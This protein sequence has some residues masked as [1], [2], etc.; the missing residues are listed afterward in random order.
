MQVQSPPRFRDRLLG[1]VLLILGLV[2]A[3]Q[4]LGWLW[5]LFSSPAAWIAVAEFWQE[6]IA[7]NAATWVP[8]A[9][10]ASAT[11]V[12]AFATWALLRIARAQVSSDAPFLSLGIID[13][14]AQPAFPQLAP[15]FAAAPQMYAQPFPTEDLA[16]PQLAPYIV[17]QAP[18]YVQLVVSN[19]QQK[20]HGA[21]ADI[22]IDM[23]LWFGA[24]DTALAHPYM[25]RRTAR[26]SALR[27]SSSTTGPIFNIGSLTGYTVMINDISYKDVQGRTRRSAVGTSFFRRY[28]SGAQVLLTRVFQPV[29]GELG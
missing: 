20:P 3:W 23:T 24:A 15:H 1:A 9:I 19:D 8:A 6:H 29:R 11:T 12:L 17:N 27:A 25:L 10:T 5:H 16:H 21:A 2:G 18:N 14:P 26:I 4:I 28:Q 7:P 13:P 22:A